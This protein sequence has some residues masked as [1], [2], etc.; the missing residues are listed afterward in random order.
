M[1]EG[2]CSTLSAADCRAAARTLRDTA[3][4]LYDH[5]WAFG[6][7]GNYSVVLERDPL[8]LLVT[9]SGRDK[10]ALADED[11]VIV[12]DEGKPVDPVGPKP[13]AETQLH[14]VL[15]RSR[16]VGAVLHTHSVWNTVL[17]DLYSPQ[18]ELTIGGYEMLKG[19]AGITTHD[20]SA[21]IAIFENTQDIAA[22]AAELAPRLERRDP[23]VRHAFLIRGHGLY[24][25]GRDLAEA[26]RHVEVLE[27]LFE[28]TARRL[29][30]TDA[31]SSAGL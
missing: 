2:I 27:F 13:S 8:R 30:L 11:F 6:T 24:T 26:R 16:E 28:V 4:L 14:V 7:C 23:A 12:G 5:G 22:L 21:Q 9:A 17:S 19:L 3:R 31:L 18:R 25:W 20:T 10:R 15:T 29:A 1:A